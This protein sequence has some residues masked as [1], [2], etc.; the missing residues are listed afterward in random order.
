MVCTLKKSIYGLKQV[1]RQWYLKFDEI[2][3]SMDFVENRVDHCIYLTINGSHFIIH[4]LFVDDIL[5]ASNDI[6]LLHEI[7]SMLSKSFDMKELND[8]SYVSG[9]E[10]HR[11]KSRCLLGFCKRP[12]S[13]MF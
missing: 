1:S 10:I 7:K 4:V 9:I 2:I 6:N 3:F 11:D 8:E 12:I 13:I 5:L